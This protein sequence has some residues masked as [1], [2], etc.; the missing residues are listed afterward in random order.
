MLGTVAYMSPEQVRGKDL[1]PR[2][3]LFSFGAVL[4][5]MATGTLPFAGDTSGVIFDGILNRA[6]VAPVRLNPQVLPKLEELINK[7]LEKDPRLRCQSA[8]EMRAD[9][10]RLR[11][12]SGSGHF[13]VRVHDSRSSFSATSPDGASAVIH[14]VT[15]KPSVFRKLVLAGAALFVL[16]V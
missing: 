10:E 16:V 12:D 2:S 9:L 7:A 8:A 13:A 4:Y 1:D 3:D 5:E 11:R 15:P 14:P 6:P